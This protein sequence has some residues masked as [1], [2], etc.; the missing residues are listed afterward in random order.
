M[1]YYPI[2]THKQAVYQDM[3]YRDI[4]PVC[5]RFSEEVLSIPVH[6]SVSEEDAGEIVSAFSEMR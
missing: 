3:G 5:E 2:P 1:V 6:P 4:L